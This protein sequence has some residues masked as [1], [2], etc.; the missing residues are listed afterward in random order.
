MSMEPAEIELGVI[1]GSGLYELAEL[2]DPRR[3]D[4]DTP[5][6]PPSDAIVVGELAGRSVAF[7]A[8][9]GSGHRISPTEIPFRANIHALKSLGVRQILSISAVGSLREEL[10][11]GTLVVPDQ[12]VDLT[13]GA[14]GASFF[15]D[16]VVAHVGFADPYCGRL[17]SLLADVA[18]PATGKQA[19][20]GGTYV[21][22]EGPQFSTRAES[23]LYRSWGMDIIGMTA[24]P[25]A[26]LAREAGI[27]YAGLALVTDYDCWRTGVEA[28]TADTVARVM[29]GNV[30]AARSVIAA[31]AP[32]GS[33]GPA[34]SCQDALAHAVLS[35][36]SAIPSR[37]RERLA[38]V[39]GKYLG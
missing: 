15:T 21:C 35:D 4:V 19:H 16:G 12:L 25:E 9:H 26:K 20:L 5:Y 37:T 36:L 33:S 27:C 34:C 3:V 24:S 2:R 7:L 23:E 38:V 30:A 32:L 6:G 17:R 11:P 28:V 29:S 1:G 39:A 14:R 22:I 18:G 31:F 13:R 8:R 10:S